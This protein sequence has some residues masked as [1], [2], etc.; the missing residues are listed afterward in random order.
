MSSRDMVQC[1]ISRAAVS[2]YNVLD[3]ERQSR[4]KKKNKNKKTGELLCVDGANFLQYFVGLE[5]RK[6]VGVIGSYWKPS[7]LH[8]SFNIVM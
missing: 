5:S 7:M 2:D 8:N 4:D 3:D 6:R 1:M